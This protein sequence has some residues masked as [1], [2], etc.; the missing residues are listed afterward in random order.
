MEK[1]ECQTGGYAK[2]RRE[3]CGARYKILYQFPI[4]FST[5]TW[6]LVPSLMVMELLG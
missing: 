2:R 6:G 4:N 5:A 3:T 1:W